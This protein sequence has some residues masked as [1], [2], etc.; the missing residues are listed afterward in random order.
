MENSNTPLQ[1]KKK[2][3]KD[4]M[5]TLLDL[6]NN[7]SCLVYYDKGQI[8][9]SKIFLYPSHSTNAMKKSIDR[10]INAEYKL[11][12]KCLWHYG[13]LEEDDMQLMEFANLDKK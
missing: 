10:K 2:V 7:C 5:V 11:W 13:Y 6:G 4:K 9:K 1:K 3:S 8:K 12:V